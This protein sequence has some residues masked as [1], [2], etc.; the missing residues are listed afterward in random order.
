MT[1]SGKYTGTLGMKVSWQH[2]TNPTCYSL[3]GLP[4]TFA[5]QVADLLEEQHFGRPRV[6]PDE[7]ALVLEDCGYSSDS[8]SELES[9]LGLGAATESMEQGITH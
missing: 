3:S 4:P 1:A 8:D 5:G 7:A 6:A 9:V 2:Q